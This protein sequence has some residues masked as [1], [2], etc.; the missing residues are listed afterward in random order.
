MGAANGGY[1][2]GKDGTLASP[3]TP[4]LPLELYN[5]AI[6]GQS[7]RGVGFRGGTWSD[8]SNYTPKISSPAT[9]T[10]TSLTGTYRSPVFL[11]IR[12]GSVNY[13]GALHGG[14]TQLVVTPAQFRTPDDVGAGVWRRYTALDL[15]LFYTGN[16]T[17]TANLAGPPAIVSVTGTPDGSGNVVF[18][19]FVAGDIN[20]PTT[21]VWITHTLAAGAAG[22]WTSLDLE[23]TRRG[24][25]AVRPLVQT[26]PPPSLARLDVG[27]PLH[28]A[29][30]HLLVSWAIDERGA[31]Y[32][33]HE[34]TLRPRLQALTR[35]RSTR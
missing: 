19:V 2:V 7:L 35:S 22:T 23:R 24:P 31:Y 14:G 16:M 15:R 27:Y 6:S 17:S 8:T 18:E 26:V 12:L 4:V 1:D 10:F 32:T 20:A 29:G 28:R 3:G 13:L 25:P 11:P 30:R 21:Q 9:D 34:R 33:V 5:V